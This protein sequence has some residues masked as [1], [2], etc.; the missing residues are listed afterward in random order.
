MESDR[1]KSSAERA[2]LLLTFGD[3]ADRVAGLIRVQPRLVARLIVAPREAVHATAAFLH[4]A[5]D[6]A[7]PDAEVAAIIHDTNPRQLLRA[8]L[9]SCPPRL[10]R[11]LDRAG[12]RV[13]SKRFYEKLG[14]VCNGPFA[15]ALLRGGPINDGR[16]TYYDALSRMD[17]T[18]AAF[19]TAL[20]ENL[21]LAEGVDCLVAVLRAHGA[22]KE[23][24]MQLPPRAGMP[25][26]VRRLR[27]VLARIVA[28]DPGF[29]PPAPF[30]FVRTTEDLQRIGKT[31]GNCVALPNWNAPKFH[32]GLVDGTAVFLVSDDPPLL[33]SLQRV[34]D[35]VWYLEQCAGPKNASPPAGARSALLRDLDAAG[36]TVVAVDPQSALGRIEQEAVCR[37]EREAEG[38]FDGEDDVAA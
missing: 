29:A 28:P 33:A 22:L 7:R 14:L 30:R 38:E 27:A 1:N 23:G 8:A 11:A 19:Q 18:T 37:R 31:F 9:P 13:Q 15:D 6:A 3:L 35:G 12:D 26:V 17:P 2:P 5:P 36:L 21:Y 24:D 4:L 32:L 34:A 20:H 10:Y 25:A 16:L